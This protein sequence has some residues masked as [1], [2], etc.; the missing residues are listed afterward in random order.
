M[1]FNRNPLSQAISTTLC[2]GA[3]ASMALASGVAFAQDQDA[4]DGVEL[5][6]VQVTGSRIKRVDIEGAQPITTITREEI[7]LTG[8]TTVADLLRSTPFNSF[9]SFVEQSGFGNGADGTSEVS[10]RGLGAQRTLILLNGRRFSR[11]PGGG[12]EAVNLN[13][14]PLDI[15]ERVEILR[16]GASA[17]YGSDAIAGVINIITRSDLE[18]ATFSYQYADSTYE[19]GEVNDFSVSGGMSGESGNV[20]FAIQH[21][22]R[23][24][25]FDAD[26]PDFA[27]AVAPGVD[28]ISSFGFPGSGQLTSGA[29]AGL[30]FVDPRCPSNVGES[31]EFPNSYRWD[32]GGFVAG[33]DQTF[34]ARCGYN[35]AADTIA[36]PAYE[37]T[38]VFLDASFDVTNNTQF[39]TTALVT[40]NEL[41]SQFAGAPVTEPVPFY[42]ADNPNNPINLFIGNTYTDPGLN[43]GNPYTFTEADRGGVAV[44]LRTVANG[45]RTSYTTND[46]ATLFAGFE[47]TNDWL[48][49][50]DWNLGYEYQRARTQSLGYNLANKVEIQ[51]AIDAGILDLFNVQGLPFDEWDAQT[52]ETLQ[53][54]NHTGIFQ[55]DTTT[56]TFD[57]SMSF[58][59]FQMNAG[60]VP[61]VLGF[62]YWDMSFNQQN[63]P[64]ANRLI[65]AGTSGGDNISG[66][67][68]D[69]LS[70]YA[71]TL[72][73][74]LSSVEIGL[75]LRYDDYSDFGT[76]W[77]PQVGI[78]WRPTD[79]LLLRATYGTGFRAPNMQELYGNVAESLPAGD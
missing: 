47:G 46:Q 65:I 79:S 63:D 68:R 59:M 28:N 17:I 19:G 31:S 78:Q 69:V 50:T 4:E 9:G 13:T 29:S 5:D 27:N 6:R 34:S 62:E 33:S 38:S 48:G 77:N 20:T 54:F 76:T 23:T 75:A 61:L 30:N 41:T 51:N 1:K 12:A 18:G 70:F 35:F 55:A 49:G 72:I 45:P 3:A 22:Q 73:P 24:P 74:V 66:V 52:T 10:L 8:F 44:F 26:I 64:E 16:D 11:E 53:L 37:R 25:I 60:P 14:I 36:I 40:Q 67:G 7:D 43:G 58:D 2:A 15:V 21:S 71:E 57:G 56:S 32:F 42:P 39:V